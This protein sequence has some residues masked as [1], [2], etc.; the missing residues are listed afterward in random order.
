MAAMVRAIRMTGAE[1]FWYVLG[2]IGFGA[3]YFAKVPVKKA[4]SEA[5]LVQLTGAEQVWYVVQC[6]ALGAG[7]FAKIPVK[8]A[9]SELAA[10]GSG[11]G[12]ASVFG[13]PSVPQPQVSAGYEPG[14]GPG[15]RPL[16]AAPSMPSGP[17][18]G[19][20]PGAR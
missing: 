5:G 14:G 18:H 17:R 11:P 8:K 7:Y 2:C 20:P 3:M 16:E 4:L 9:L 6:I 13:M 1:S 10:A 12:A 19:R 15:G